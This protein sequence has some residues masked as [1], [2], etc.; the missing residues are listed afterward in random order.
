MS[1]N[2]NH[3]LVCTSHNFM[4]NMKPNNLITA[5]FNFWNFLS[6]LKFK[7]LFGKEWQPVHRSNN[8][9]PKTLTNTATGLFLEATSQVGVAQVRS[10]CLGTQ[11]RHKGPQTRY[12]KDTSSL[13]FKTY[14]IY[15]QMP[16]QRMPIS[17]TKRTYTPWILLWM[18]MVYSRVTT[19]LM[20]E[21]PFFFSP[22]FFAGAISAT[23]KGTVHTS[24]AKLGRSPSS[25]LLPPP[26]HYKLHNSHIQKFKH[27]LH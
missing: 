2:P 27:K 22:P 19:S 13:L 8:L 9:S 6:G 7:H 25:S 15:F 4:I 23:L 21:R 24:N 17:V 5:V 10:C 12:S 18:L 26:A 3:I 16:L 14:R 20:A 1:F 11:P